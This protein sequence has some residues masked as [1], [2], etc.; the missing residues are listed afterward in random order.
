[1]QSMQSII[2]CIWDRMWIATPWH[3]MTTRHC[4]KN[5]VLLTS[6]PHVIVFKW[7]I[8][9]HHYSS[10]HHT[11]FAQFRFIKTN[12]GCVSSPFAKAFPSHASLENITE[13]A[14][15]HASSD[16]ERGNNTFPCSRYATPRFLLSS[17]E[18]KWALH[19]LGSRWSVHDLASTI[20]WTRVHASFRITPSVTSRRAELRTIANNRKS[21]YH[22]MGIWL[23]DVIMYKLLPLALKNILTPYYLSSTPSVLLS[24]HPR[25]T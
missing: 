13:W 5:F 16:P 19:P 25:L 7:A 22:H 18:T 15:D 6:T 1:M 20:C 3:I 23:A 9:A 14:R 4:V 21:C 11:K 8:W 17:A 10:H 12:P 2:D 24:T